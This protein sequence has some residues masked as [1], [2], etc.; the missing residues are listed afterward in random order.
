MAILPAVTVPASL[1][2]RLA[3]LFVYFSVLHQNSNS[4]F[5]LE[6]FFLQS[7]VTNLYI[8]V[9]NREI[10]FCLLLISD[11]CFIWGRCIMLEEI[12]IFKKFLLK[13][14]DMAHFWMF[15]P[16]EHWDH[17]MRQISLLEPEFLC[18]SAIQCAHNFEHT[19]VLQ[20][21]EEEE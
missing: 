11:I 17:C 19:W 15:L 21:K 5:Q 2:H 6:T 10:K 8:G 3:F 16:S 18:S 1:V 20:N 4:W 7:R 13:I 14:I 12:F 9:Q